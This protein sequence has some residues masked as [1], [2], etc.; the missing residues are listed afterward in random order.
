M[1]GRLVI[2][3]VALLSI[4]LGIGLSTF[5]TKPVHA[6][7][8]AAGFWRLA[9]SSIDYCTA[10]VTEGAGTY[11][12]NLSCTGP[13]F[14][15]WSGTFDSTSGANSGSLY[16]PPVGIT[17]TTT[18]TISGDTWT[19]TWS[20]GGASGS[21]AGTRYATHYTATPDPVT[22][23]GGGSLTTAAE[24]GTVF[25]IPP[26]S[27]SSDTSI[28]LDIG[29]VPQSPPLPVGQY[30]IAKA[31]TFNPA[32]TN[33]NPCAS[34]V[35][36]YTLAELPSGADPNLLQVY[37]HD[38]TGWHLVGGAVDTTAQT[39]TVSICHF[40]MYAV[41][42]VLDPAADS[43][44]DGTADGAEVAAGTDPSSSAPFCAN[45]YECDGF[46]N[47]SPSLH[48]GPA[49]TNAARDNCMFA[50]NANQLNNDGNYLDLPTKA[51]D[52][53]TRPA[54]DGVGDACDADD[55]NDGLSDTDELSGAGCASTASDPMKADTDGDNF[56]DG[57]E[58]ALGTDPTIMFT[59]PAEAS[60]GAAGDAD[61]DGVLTRREICYYNTDPN[62]VNTDGDACRDG[63]EIASVNASNS[64]D[65]IDL[66]Q[67]ASE[68]GFYSL[69]G[70]PVKVNF[71]VNR[72]GT[73]D[74][75]DLQF[76][77]GRSGPCP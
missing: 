76:V 58:C 2:L 55:D 44:G 34:A 42:G 75:I 66:Q 27:L 17:V 40:S 68:A 33:F 72:S 23:T 61:G 65:V 4:V 35:F 39:I 32:G 56:L 48:Q 14:S 70:S 5:A 10:E 64:V 13:W 6:A 19:G 7:E 11:S 36:K 52:D 49:N 43:D 29:V 24:D 12:A 31:Y 3:K 62:N 16:Y 30:T 45:D 26:N 73:I 67:V 74:V 25:T 60:C 57:A 59:K 18:G 28:T 8:T 20:A 21:F 9:Y 38:S 69:P 46:P 53:T 15:S 22:A 37:I 41:F 63:K 77:A 1:Y 51:F 50:A 54:S 71:D 47:A